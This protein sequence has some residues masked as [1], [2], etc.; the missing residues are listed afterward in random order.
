MTQAPKRQVLSM[1]VETIFD[2]GRNYFNGFIHHTLFYLDDCL[3]S[4]IKN[5]FMQEKNTAESDETRKQIIPYVVVR[6]S[7]NGIPDHFVRY[8]RK[9]DV[10][11]ERLRKKLS[12]GVG[13]HIEEEDIQYS[14]METIDRCVYRELKEEL[15][16]KN[17][18][19]SD[20][21][22]LC[23]II[24]YVNEDES[25]V[26]RVHLGV[27]VV[28]DIPPDMA[29][30]IEI[31]ANE[32]L[33]FIEFESAEELQKQIEDGA[34]FEAWSRFVIPALSRTY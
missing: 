6:I 28:F 19:F 5:R 9:S 23:S 30:E 26:G 31:P 27:V 3:E 10:G 15:G 14:L 17:L 22:D 11:D 32:A 12:I 1:P 21:S 33:S 8:T 20:T 34:N 29:K 24:G 13:G 7:G 25:E 4:V 2:R 18:S 16:L